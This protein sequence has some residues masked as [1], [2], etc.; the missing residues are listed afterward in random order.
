MTALDSVCTTKGPADV[1]HDSLVHGGCPASRI[2]GLYGVGTL[3]AA[4]GDVRWFC[5][6]LQPVAC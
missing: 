3:Q 6:G 4:G 5:D 1:V 2:F